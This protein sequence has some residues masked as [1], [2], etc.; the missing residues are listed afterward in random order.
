ME[1]GESTASPPAP[2]LLVEQ[3]YG[4]RHPECDL[5]GIVFDLDDVLGTLRRRIRAAAAIT[6]DHRAD[7]DRERLINSYLSAL[8]RRSNR[9]PAFA[10][11]GDEVHQFERIRLGRKTSTEASLFFW[12]FANVERGSTRRS[13]PLR[14]L[15][16]SRPTSARRRSNPLRRSA[17]RQTDFRFVSI[18]PV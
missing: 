17:V 9:H 4:H 2:T 12:L 18:K 15:P 5:T 1:R 6:A 11:K 7:I 16:P 13:R 14:Q 8:L 3:D 10:D